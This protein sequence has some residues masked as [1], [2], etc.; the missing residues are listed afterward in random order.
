MTA[1]LDHP[2]AAALLHLQIPHAHP[3]RP[4]A[5]SQLNCH[6]GHWRTN[7]HLYYDKDPGY[8]GAPPEAV[9]GDSHSTG[10]NKSLIS[11]F[12]ETKQLFGCERACPTLSSSSCSPPNSA[13]A[14]MFNPPHS[15]AP[16]YPTPSPTTTATPAAPR[17]AR[18]PVPLPFPAA[19]RQ[20]GGSPHDQSSL[21]P[22]QRPA[23]ARVRETI[24][25]K[26]P[27][28]AETHDHAHAVI[29][30]QATMISVA[31]Y[32]RVAAGHDPAGTTALFEYPAVPH[33]GMS[34][35]AGGPSSDLLQLR[36]H[37]AHHLPTSA[38]TVKLEPRTS[39]TEMQHYGG[40]DYMQSPQQSMQSA[41]Y[42]YEYPPSAY[43]PLPGG[44][45]EQTSEMQLFVAPHESM[46]H[47]GTYQHETHAVYPGNPRGAGSGMTFGGA[48]NMPMKP[49][50]GMGGMQA[51]GALMPPGGGGAGPAN[52][53]MGMRRGSAGRQAKTPSQDRPYGCPMEHCERR[54]SRSDELTRHLRIHTG[55]KPF[56]CRI[57]HRAFSRS[58]HLTTHVRTHTGEKPFSCDICGRRFARSDEKKR[59][60]KVHMKHPKT[61]GSLVPTGSSSS[62]RQPRT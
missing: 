55:Q 34:E 56:Q 38:R 31:Q 24:H 39:P 62:G 53:P 25:T 14:P 50:Y 35:A 11:P 22:H 26:Q 59:H 18:R 45:V 21:F 30:E 44:G 58:D 4:A 13:G 40:G 54:F 7:N 37:S 1:L 46:Q 27:W 33:P 17:P 41:H 61:A 52:V 47:F 9:V 8:E 29:L 42:G 5:A 49:V 32:R 57:C 2:S 12:V 16:P 15:K 48:S 36:T 3:L 43:L 19:Y 20:G 10:A 60:T 28:G 23:G 6:A 51:V